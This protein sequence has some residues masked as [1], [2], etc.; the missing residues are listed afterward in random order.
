MLLALQACP[1]TTAGFST[2]ALAEQLQQTV[3]DQ[4][5]DIEALEVERNALR[6]QKTA[7]EALLE[8]AQEAAAEAQQPSTSMLHGLEVSLQATSPKLFL[9][10]F[11]SAACF[12][13]L[14]AGSS[15][16]HCA[17]CRRRPQWA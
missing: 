14:F 11:H 3:N 2:Q 16:T 7:L 1:L 13:L 4:E 5:L 9:A 8:S 12:A 10:L 17:C 6:D 15:L